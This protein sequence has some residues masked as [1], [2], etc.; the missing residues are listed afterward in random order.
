M[1]R[2]AKVNLNLTAL[3][4]N[5][6]RVKKL[7]PKSCILS[8]VKADAYGHGLTQVA[9]TLQQSDAFGVACVEE[10]MELRDA[11]V[12]KPI[13]LLEGPFS[14]EELT[15]VAALKLDIVVHNEEQ[16]LMIERFQSEYLLPVW[17]KIDTGMHRLGFEPESI[18][19]VYNKLL[20]LKN[21]KDEIVL[22]SHYA[23]AGNP[24]ANITKLQSTKFLELTQDLSGKRSICNSAGI[25]N[26][27]NSHY[28]YV[29]PGLM[30][31]GVSPINNMVSADFDLIPVMS[32]HSAL[33]AIKQVSKG[34]TVGY[35]ATWQCP[36]DMPVGIVAIG[37]GDGY[38]RHAKSGT[39]VIINGLQ[40]QLIG[41][42]SMDM[43][44]VD[45]RGIRGAKIGDPVELWGESL[46][47]DLVAKH[48]ETIA[49]ELLSGVHKR[50]NVNIYDEN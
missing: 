41:N 4:K 8:V 17:L 26:Q 44:T 12:M 21:V 18:K 35:G 30:L 50:L 40:T 22:M 42:P 36:E 31:Y 25:I 39:P 5:F 48:A 47:V 1:S 11:G 28:D 19:Q 29:R 49:Y 46:P 6:S 13:L 14:F 27:A 32:L 15:V 33:I 20:S 45:L 2:P 16:I 38:P 24:D 9:E 34:E 23:D 43:I 3:R 37:Y 7:S 10:A